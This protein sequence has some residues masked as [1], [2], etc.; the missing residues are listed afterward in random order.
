MTK[1]D[2]APRRITAVGYGESRPLVNE[3]S[4]A[5]NARNR[6]IEAAIIQLPSSE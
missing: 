6:R 4:E 5:A 1:A 2:I 3:E